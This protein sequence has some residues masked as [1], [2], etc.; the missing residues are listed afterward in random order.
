MLLHDEGIFGS[1]LCVF[2]GGLG[3]SVEAAFLPV[4]FE[5]G[6]ESILSQTLSWGPKPPRAIQISIKLT[7]KRPTQDSSCF[8]PG[9][10]A[11]L[12]SSCPVPRL[13]PK[14]GP[15]GHDH[16]ERPPPLWPDFDAGPHVCRGPR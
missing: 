15:H 11:N 12:K 5:L 7:D 1:E 9:W 16:L 8:L 6:H 10:A 2:A 13:L 14:E 4:F 3:G